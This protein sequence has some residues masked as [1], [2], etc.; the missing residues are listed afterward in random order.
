[1]TTPPPAYRSALHEVRPFRPGDREGILA[2]YRTVFGGD[3]SPEWFAWKY[4]NNPYAADVPIV[5][6]TIDGTVV[7]CRAFFAL[8]MAVE[9]ESHLALQ[10]CDTMVHPD[11]RRRG[12]FVRMNRLAVERYADRPPAFCFNFPNDSSKPGNE[13]VGWRP[14]G[15]VPMYYRVA[16]PAGAL[17]ALAG[18]GDRSGPRSRREL[19]SPGPIAGAVGT[20]HQAGDRLFARSS[21]QIRRHDDPPIATLAALSRRAPPEGIHAVRSER[22][23]RWRLAN[24]ERRY[25]AHVAVRDGEAVAAAVVSP[26]SDHVRIVD[27]VPR[28]GVLGARRDLVAGICREYADR[29]YVTAFGAVLDDPLWYRFL[30]DTRL[31]L[32]AVIR[33]TTRTLYARDL[34]ARTV[35]G[36]PI[37]DWSL[38]RLALDTA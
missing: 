23:Y 12:L 26:A 21:Y 37:G 5:V 1:M 36:R 22:F 29:P 31:P 24:P 8:E 11:H 17:A 38:S 20:A 10:P 9:G 4:E 18:N 32:S 19:S 14:V 34:G 15:R 2:L 7:G 13:A 35:E 6:A 25:H 16:D 28:Q 33:P 30:P 27:M 3:P